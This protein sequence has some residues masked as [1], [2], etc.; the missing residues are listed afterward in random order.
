MFCF[1]E[2]L[3]VFGTI[4]TLYVFSFFLVLWVLL[5]LAENRHNLNA[6]ISILEME[7]DDL[8]QAVCK[9]IMH[10]HAL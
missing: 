2:E 4:M 3:L 5:G 7:N 9:L 10:W 1:I 8:K 6:N